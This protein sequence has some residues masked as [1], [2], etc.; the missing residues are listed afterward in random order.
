LLEGKGTDIQVSARGE[1]SM[2]MASS[3]IKIDWRELGGKK[4]R[5]YLAGLSTSA[6]FK[7]HYGMDTDSVM[8]LLMDKSSLEHGG[9]IKKRMEWRVSCNKTNHAS[10]STPNI[11]HKLTTPIILVG[12]IKFQ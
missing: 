8:L 7:I 10:Y 9:R 3:T 2:D 5:M 1:D 6:N 11:M 12:L 4:Y